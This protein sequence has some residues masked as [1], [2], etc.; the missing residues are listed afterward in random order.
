MCHINRTTTH[1]KLSWC[2]HLGVPQAMLVLH[3]Q[4][5]VYVSELCGTLFGEFPYRSTKLR[6]RE[7][8]PLLNCHPCSPCI[9]THT[10]CNSALYVAME[11]L[12]ACLPHH[13]HIMGSL[14][15]FPVPAEP[16]ITSI[17]FVSLP[18]KGVSP[19]LNPEPPHPP[20]KPAE[21]S[22]ELSSSARHISVSKAT[23]R[24]F[25]ETAIKEM[26]WKE[27]EGVRGCWGVPLSI[28]T[29]VF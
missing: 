2:R 15:L 18:S 9:P 8:H 19:S 28:L 13:G 23:S 7:K 3:I 1:S 24:D 17:V 11:G 25:L 21:P 5:A 20:G 10:L 6:Q 29:C 4:T 27:T 22:V 16:H 26:D 14:Q 12:P